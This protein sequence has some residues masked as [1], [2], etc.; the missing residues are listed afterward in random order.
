MRTPRLVSCIL[1]ALACAVLLSG[2]GRKAWPEPRLSD[3]VFA[4]ENATAT[5]EKG[6]ITVNADV[7]G[8]A[9]KIARVY[10]ELSSADCPG[11]PFTPDRRIEFTRASADLRITADKLTLSACGLGNE[12]LMWRITAENIHSAIR[13]TAT[14][15]QMVP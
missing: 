1:A 11:C 2:C 9:D 12:P 14:A 8:K 3:D 7:T 5:L 13:G 15:V 10:L 6:C 4:F